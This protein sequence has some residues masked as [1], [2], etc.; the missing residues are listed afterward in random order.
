MGITAS[1]LRANVY[2]LIDRVIE[3]GQPLEIERNG[4]IVRI[5]AVEPASRLAQLPK[6]PD[7]VRGDPEELVHLDWSAEWT[8]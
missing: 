6:R 7:F 4:H 8:P 5:I 2:Q 3:T 1:E